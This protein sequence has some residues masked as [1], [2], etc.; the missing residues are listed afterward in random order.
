MLG[1]VN[2]EERQDGFTNQ[3]ALRTE[4]SSLRKAN[5]VLRKHQRA[6]GHEYG[7]EGPLL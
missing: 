2:R 4:V 3:A 1:A 6:K 7:L 5:E